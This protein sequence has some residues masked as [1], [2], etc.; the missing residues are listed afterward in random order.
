MG[1]GQAE[2][3]SGGRVQIRGGRWRG[4]DGSGSGAGTRTCK[5]QKHGEGSRKD[6][7]VVEER[8]EGSRGQEEGVSPLDPPPPFAPLLL[9]A[10][11]QPSVITFYT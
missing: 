8:G 5:Y 1:G 6:Q 7:V 10:P 4:E 2:A 9:L 3:A 11:L